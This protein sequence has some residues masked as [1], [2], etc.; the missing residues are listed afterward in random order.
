MAT[1]NLKVL[2]S[3]DTK[4]YRQEIDLAAVKT[5]Q[6]NADISAA[7]EQMKDHV[8]S[9]LNAL[10]GLFGA[11]LGT[12]GTSSEKIATVFKGLS[13]SL[14]A[15]ASGGTA[16]SVASSQVVDANIAIAQAEARS[17]VANEALAIAQGNTAISAEAMAAAE[18]EASGAAK[19]L[20]TAQESLA[21]AQKA[22][23]VATDIGTRS[24]EIFKVAM[25]STGI[26]AL[27][28]VIGSLIAFFTETREGANKV[29][30]AMAE[31]SAAGRILIDHISAIGAALYHFGEAVV[32]AVSKHEKLIT[33]FKTIITV[34][35]PVIA[36]LKFT[37]VLDEMKAAGDAAGQ[38]A[39][40]TQAL[41]KEEREN[42]VTQKQRLTLVEQ[43]KLAARDEGIT[44]ENKR[45]LLLQA[46]G[47]IIEYYDE[48]K[49]IA[50][51]RRDIAI[52][53]G[54]LSNQSGAQLNNIEELKAHVIELDG[55][56]AEAQKSIVQTIKRNQ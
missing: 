50:E 35:S 42:I 37:G 22:V 31:L 40:N 48:E 4:P 38:L 6:M 16:F 28:V 45:R 18:L 8:G 54:K 39:I 21:V 49:R 1:K 53:Q 24:L 23:A 25:I 20:K 7:T 19:A 43:L 41:N 26:G 36:L 33:A 17:I 51:G 55:Q 5:K 46:K 32:D 9:Q 47:L 56:S 10:A 27:I 14:S 3:G 11:N 29:K 12:I 15:A 30:V 44:A 2:M 52:E 13:T 34:A